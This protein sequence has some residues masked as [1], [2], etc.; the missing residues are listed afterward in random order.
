MMCWKPDRRS[1][2]GGEARPL[3]SD[4]ATGTLEMRLSGPIGL[5]LRGPVEYCNLNMRLVAIGV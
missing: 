5:C 1:G 2:A 4:R 3:A